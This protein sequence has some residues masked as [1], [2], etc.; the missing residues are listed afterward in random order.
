MRQVHHPMAL[1]IS[2]DSTTWW[3]D[4]SSCSD[5]GRHDPVVCVIEKDAATTMRGRVTV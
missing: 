5:G 3:S 4:K 2:I 1:S